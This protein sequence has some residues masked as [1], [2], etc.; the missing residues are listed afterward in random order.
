[1]VSSWAWETSSST[2]SWWE[3]LQCMTCSPCLHPTWQSL[4]AWEP[5]CCCWRSRGKHC[6][7]CPSV[8]LWGSRS[9]SWRALSWN[10]LLCLSA[11][12][13]FTSRCCRHPGTAG[14]FRASW[15]RERLTSKYPHFFVG[16]LQPLYADWKG[17]F[18]CVFCFS[19]SVQLPLFGLPQGKIPRMRI[20]I[21]GGCLK[22]KQLHLPATSG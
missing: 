20:Q 3:G 1:M 17:R 21:C 16:T 9:I 14:R 7:P 19:A 5:P 22:K 15:D 8:S 10:H 2:V 12:T 4:R 13:C 11:C 18:Q 6:L